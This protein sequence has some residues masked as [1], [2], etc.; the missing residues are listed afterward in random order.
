MTMRSV[1][2]A[3]WL[4]ATAVVAFAVPA[5][6]PYEVVRDHDTIVVAIDGSYVENREQAYRVLDKNGIKILQERKLFYTQGFETL[7]IASAY[8]LKPDGR[9]I[10]VPPGG[11]L[12][13]F[14]QT[15]QRGFGDN[16]IVS[17]FFPN[18]EI[19]DQ[20]VLVL[21]H[22]QLTPFFPGY[23]D[24][25]FLFSRSLPSHD[26]VYS[27]SVPESLALK[28][29][30][31][32]VTG[33]E[34]VREN[35]MV[36]RVWRFE[37]ASPE[38]LENDAVSEED[39]APHLNLT[40]FADYADVAQAYRARAKDKTKITPEIAALADKLTKG[41]AD[42]R[43]QAKILYEWVSSNIAY[44]AIELGT[45]G[46]TPHAARDILANRFG[47]CKDHVTLLEALLS[48]KGIESTPALI[49]IGESTYRLPDAASPHAFDHVITYLPSFDLFLDATS[50]LAPF[51]VLPYSDSG[52]PVVLV[53]DGRQMRTPVPTSAQSKVAVQSTVDVEADGSISGHTKLTASGALGMQVRA[54]VLGIDAGK[55]NE[56]L[57]NIMGPGAEGTI[58][59]GQPTSMRDPYE[60]SFDFRLPGALSF[61]GPGALPFSL[62]PRPF[63]FTEMVA[64]QLPTARGSDYVCHSMEVEE[65]VKVVFPPGI[66]LLAIPDGQVVKGDGI[67]LQTDYERSDQR[68]LRRAVNLR[69]DHPN[70][71]C[72]PAYYDGVRATLKKMTGILRQQ[73]VYRGA[74]DGAE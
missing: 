17:V 28:I 18:L 46:F 35:G 7:E 63:S 49:R 60:V 32:G 12:S 9:R 72:A 5:T 55:E 52:K 71:S 62:A 56:F 6:P 8:T 45:G 11:V 44:V 25:R 22:K 31:A 41:V 16:H 58:E 54:M 3:L 51:G 39:F 47:D 64:G 57:R 30:A 1:W 43:E 10:D 38:I 67:R 2:G 34:A 13:G 40:T 37:N 24:A 29:D 23:F 14:G 36:R 20:T 68:T 59:R 53:A 74:A 27:V 42:K 73:V 4:A 26:R 70:A 19:G 50:E 66:R 65:T 61:P 48:A 15:S 33:G 69:I 21:R